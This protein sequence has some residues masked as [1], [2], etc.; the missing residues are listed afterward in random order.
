MFESRVAME[1]WGIRYYSAPGRYW[2]MNAALRASGPA[3]HVPLEPMMLNARRMRFL[4]LT[5]QQYSAA[6][7]VIEALPH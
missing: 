1:P 3:H 6:K 7:A 5:S 4:E 2:G